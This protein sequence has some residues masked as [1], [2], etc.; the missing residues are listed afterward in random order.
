MT[1]EEIL[2]QPDAV[3][4]ECKEHFM[5][6]EENKPKPKGPPKYIWELEEDVD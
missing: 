1:N 6:M 4:Q 3:W 2:A 5:D